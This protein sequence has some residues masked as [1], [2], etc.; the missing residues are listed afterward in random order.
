MA[1]KTVISK[2]MAAALALAAHDI[3][4]ATVD[5]GAISASGHQIGPFGSTG[6][7]VSADTF[8]EAGTNL[9]TLDNDTGAQVIVSN[10]GLAVQNSGEVN[11]ATGE[12]VDDSPFD[13]DGARANDI[14]I[15]DFGQTVRLSEIG[16]RNADDND[17]FIFFA[18]DDLMD[19][20]GP[21]FTQKFDILDTNPGDA[22]SFAFAPAVTARFFGIGAL[23]AADNFRVGSL[24]FSPVP[25]PPSLAFMLAGLAGFAFLS[26][27]AS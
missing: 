11:N 15:F 8:S 7:V 18:L 16:F 13:I 1:W 17:D 22:G 10:E 20:S 9:I 14:L 23:D 3:S 21:I 12:T 6:L 25:I 27:R 2:C 5:F 19:L 24:E 26:R 4:A